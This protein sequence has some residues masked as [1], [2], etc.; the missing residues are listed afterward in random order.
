MQDAF[1]FVQRGFDG[2][3]FVFGDR[4]FAVGLGASISHE[5]VA[6]FC[7]DGVYVGRPYSK[8][9]LSQKRYTDLLLIFIELL[10]ANLIGEG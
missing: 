9:F 1:R 4:K 7:E 10:Y 8:G 6:E 2:S 3:V 5:V